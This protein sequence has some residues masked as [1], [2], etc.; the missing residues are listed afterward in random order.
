M[1]LNVI[2]LNYNILKLE[3]LGSYFERSK[4]HI[5]VASFARGSARVFV[6]YSS[7]E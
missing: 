1:S 3:Y 2:I 6:G 7:K 4:L 5:Y